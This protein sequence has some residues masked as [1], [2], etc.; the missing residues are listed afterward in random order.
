LLRQ[1][2][3]AANVEIEK[4]NPVPTAIALP[5]AVGA[6]ALIAAGSKHSLALTTAGQVFCGRRRDENRRG[7]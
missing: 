5:G 6:I 2:G 4:P 3:G 7:R 1:T